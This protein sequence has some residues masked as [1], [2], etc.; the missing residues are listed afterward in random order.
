MGQWTP[1]TTEDCEFVVRALSLRH[2][3]AGQTVADTSFQD[4][5]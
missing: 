2:G 3:E 4:A 5:A 1:G